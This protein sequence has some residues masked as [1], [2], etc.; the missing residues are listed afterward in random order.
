MEP[1][2]RFSPCSLLTAFLILLPI[3]ASV[4]SS[5]PVSASDDDLLP[6]LDWA[7]DEDVQPIYVAVKRAQRMPFSG[8]MYGKRAAM[9]FSGGMYGKRAAMP[10]SG[11]MYGKR[12]A[13]PFSGGMYGKRGERMLRSMPLSGGMYGR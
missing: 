1:R 2:S 9:P 10:F 5:L 8:G 4:I 3:F 7:S 11:G 13:M 6:M 12:A